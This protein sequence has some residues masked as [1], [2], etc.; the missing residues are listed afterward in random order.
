M[1]LTK[2]AE[3]LEG[4]PQ[5]GSVVNLEGVRADP[6]A[7]L[8]S[9]KLELLR[10]LNQAHSHRKSNNQSEKP[11]PEGTEAKEDKLHT[12]ATAEQ[13]ENVRPG[14]PTSGFIVLTTHP[15]LNRSGNDFNKVNDYISD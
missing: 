9:H 5:S 14:G 10:F 4:F 11:S 1:D 8:L 6:H 7:K 13:K 12:Q 15:C 2:L 3:E